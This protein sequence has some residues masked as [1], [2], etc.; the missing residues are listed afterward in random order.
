M[1]EQIN[2]LKMQS[3]ILHQFGFSTVKVCCSLYLF[4]LTYLT[5][6]N[7]FMCNILFKVLLTFLHK[8]S[9]VINCVF[10]LCLCL[11]DFS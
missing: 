5:A 11:H 8:I 3:K 4:N 6:V 9:Y 1:E 7:V 10:K 2:N